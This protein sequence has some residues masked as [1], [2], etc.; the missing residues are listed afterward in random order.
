MPNWVI[1]RP[2]LPV[3]ELG[4]TLPG[5]YPPTWLVVTLVVIIVIQSISIYKLGGCKHRQPEQQQQH[6]ETH[7]VRVQAQTTYTEVDSLSGSV[8]RFKPLPGY[9]QGA[10]REALDAWQ[11]AY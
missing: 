11:Q 9:A 2:E 8:P 4:N 5:L 6:V 3:V 1:E 10:Q 7:N